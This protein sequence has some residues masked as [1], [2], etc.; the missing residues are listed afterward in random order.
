M[1]TSLLFFTVLVCTN[2]LYAQVEDFAGVDL[3]KAD[4]IAG[5]YPGHSLSDLK[6]LSDKLTTPLSTDV[7]KF[8]AIYRWVCNNI[9][10]DY[11]LYSRNKHKRENL[12]DADELKKW[13]TKI[14]VK[15]FRTL[16]EK[17]RTVCTGYAY[18]VKEL[19]HH[20]GIRVEIIDGYGRTAVSNIGGA[21][22]P[23]HTWNAVQLGNKWYLCD[24]T[25]SSGA[26][27]INKGV[28]VKAYNDSYFLSEP[29]SFIRN[30]YPLDT[31]WILMDRKP[32]LETFLHRPLIYSA[33]FP[34]KID[35]LFPETFAITTP[36]RQ[37]VT[38][39][40]T[41]QSSKPLEKVELNI[42]GRTE[43][44]NAGLYQDVDGRYCID[45]TFR[46]KGKYVVHI[47]FD[48][49]HAFT[50]TVKVI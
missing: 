39:R 48:G 24:A 25:W 10:N 20:A 29:S 42:D 8:R 47:L 38:F 7:E 36:R 30:H 1:R 15:V 18:L 23:N 16:L 21:G 33:I 27:D 35:Q 2:S 11:T 9:D 17:H 49:N 45:H 34:F 40:F 22:I 28:F 31:A 50:Y 5:L 43:T 46:S 6:L 13:N 12:K 19:A 26:I 14:S 3:K 41:K 37:A 32:T 4:S 44:A